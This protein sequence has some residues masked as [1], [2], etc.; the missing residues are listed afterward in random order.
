[1]RIRYTPN[2]LTAVMRHHVALLVVIGDAPYPHLAQNFVNTLERI[3]GFI[4]CH[5][6]PYIAKIY[7]PGEPRHDR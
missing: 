4:A 1:M 7:R 3:E 5:E 2:E 6:T